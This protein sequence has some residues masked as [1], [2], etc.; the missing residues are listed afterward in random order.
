VYFVPWWLIVLLRFQGGKHLLKIVGLVI[1]CNGF[2][3]G[4]E[5][6][7][8]P[9]TD[10]VD[11][12]K[13]AKE[14]IWYQIFPERF[15]NGDANNDPQLADIRG[16]W[17]HDLESPYAISAWTGD[18]YAL[19]S[20]EDKSR[21]FYYHVQR[22]RYGGDLQGILDK[23]D[24]LSELGI[25]AIYF[26]PL[27]ESPSLHK[28]DGA[29]YHHIDDNFGPN[30]KRDREIISNESPDNPA[31]WKWTTADSLFLKLVK[32]CHRRNIKV[33]IDGVFNH[34]GLNFWAF[35]DVV[36]NQQNSRYLNWFTINRW[37]D[38]DT[39]ENEFDYKGWFGVKELP[40]LRED[41]NGLVAEARQYIFD[42][43][44]RWMD[45]N[46]DGDP[47]DGIDGWRLDVADMVGTAFWRDFRR[48]V[49][50]INPEAY[51]VGEVW[52]EDWGN[53]K[54]FNASPWLNGD[55]FDAVMN[56]RWAQEVIHFFVDRKN[57]IT[58][59]QFD[60]RL[61]KLRSDYPQEVNYA[62]MNVMDSHDTDRLSSQIVNPDD[63]YDH[64]DN[65]KDNPE[66]NVRKP[67]GEEIQTQKLIAL[68]QMTYVGAPVIYYGDE[69]GMWGAD[70]PDSRKPMLWPDRQ[71]DQ[72]VS[73]PFG[74][75]RPAD[76]NQFNWE[77]FNY[78][79]KLISI[80]QE[81]SSLQIGE[82]ETLF[83]NDDK[84]VYVFRRFS[85]SE[86]L[87]IAL[88]NSDS[89]QT[90][91]LSVDRLGSKTSWTDLLTQKSFQVA[92]KILK[93]D[94]PKVTGLILI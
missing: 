51:L 43:V 18:W 27:F 11:V 3:W 74:K 84:D 50:G 62:L 58:A 4:C 40:E 22:R 71:Y 60:K 76:D 39:P 25:N 64:R 28:Y 54:M 35:Q 13:W 30:P 41:R 88:N 1:L 17:P 15:N 75:Y 94:I 63:D 6:R 49:R 21:G 86:S 52:W 32:E 7:N 73:H 89:S 80:R 20:W 34:V 78:Y 67:T 46:N 38:P 12:P 92:G 90:I 53:N 72:E 57:K 81:H 19:Q 66:Y 31:T 14:A 8:K 79:K 91:F 9:A 93:L 70:D 68:F 44:K 77:L 69:A 36:Q 42:S 45:P 29:T 47:S 23:L 37:D 55:T 87:I 5:K 2:F 33:I 61:K 10:P 16:S 48:L 83:T 24:Y 85:G 82:I 65:P 56:Y 26:N 59:S